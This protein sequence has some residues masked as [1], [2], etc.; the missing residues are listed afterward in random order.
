MQDIETSHALRN[1]IRLQGLQ[2][3]E[4]ELLGQVERAPKEIQH[5][6]EELAEKRKIVEEAEA[7]I[8]DSGKERR[9]LEGDVEDL[10]R[11]LAHYRDQLMEVKTN[12]EYQAMLHEI[13]YVEKQISDK[14]DLILEQML[15][16]EELDQKLAEARKTFREEEEATLAKRKELEALIIDSGADL[17][18]VERERSR[19]EAEIPGEFLQRYQRIAAARAGIAV[20]KVINHSCEA[21]HVRLRPQLLAE[22]RTNQQIILCENCNRILYYSDA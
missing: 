4:S 16:T 1:L 19:I 2:L 22:L 8:T 15:E 7:A 10:R 14:E 18:E 21:C 9:K 20:T 5:L 17:E 13:E 3:K 11:R 6:E 12:T